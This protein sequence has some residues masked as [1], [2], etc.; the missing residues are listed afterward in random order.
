MITS[1]P[2]AAS[3]FPTNNWR[4]DVPDWRYQ[5]AAPIGPSGIAM[6]G[7]TGHF[8]SLG[9]KRITS[10]SDDGTVRITIAFTPGETSRSLRGYSPVLSPPSPVT[11][12][13]SPTTRL[14]AS[15]RSP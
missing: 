7:D 10:L 13:P 2:P 3:F 6:L 1:P 9:K 14:P 8:V 15:S 12:T 11:S 5:I 4:E